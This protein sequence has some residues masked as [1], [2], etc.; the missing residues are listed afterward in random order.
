MKTNR[1]LIEDTLNE[2]C[3]PVPSY[4]MGATTQNIMR[5]AFREI[6]ECF[7]RKQGGN[8]G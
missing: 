6:L 8:R 1:E 5:E 7:V 2:K 4:E 3:P